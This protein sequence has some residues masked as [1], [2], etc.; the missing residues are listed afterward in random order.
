MSQFIPRIIESTVDGKYVNKVVSSI[1]GQRFKFKPLEEIEYLYAY[2]DSHEDTN[3]DD[4]VYVGITNY[5][6]FKFDNGNKFEIFRKDIISVKYIEG[7]IFHF[8]KILFDLKEAEA[9][10]GIY[11]S[12]TCKF[13]CKYLEDTPFEDPLI[14]LEKRLKEAKE[15][16]V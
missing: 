11:E 8:D 9:M 4:N 3:I 13:L 14:K 12:K 16:V 10:I 7:G 1:L 2:G 15:S 6:V 5:R